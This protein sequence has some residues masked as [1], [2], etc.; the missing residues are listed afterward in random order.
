MN[1]FYFS[2]LPVVGLFF[3]LDSIISTFLRSLI[4]KE[5]PK[6]ASSKGTG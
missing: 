4:N 2:F 5:T 1:Y 3:L 6:L